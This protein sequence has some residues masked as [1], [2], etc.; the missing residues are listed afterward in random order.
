M[1]PATQHQGRSLC[2]SE[3]EAGTRTTVQDCA[4][5]HCKMLGR[6]CPRGAVVMCLN[7]VQFR[8]SLLSH[9]GMSAGLDLTEILQDT[10][11][12][13]LS[14]TSGMLLALL[15]VSWIPDLLSP[16]LLNYDVPVCV[17]VSLSP[18]PD[19]SPPHLFLPPLSFSTAKSNSRPHS[20]DG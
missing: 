15:A 4:G 5:S 14:P 7:L 6:L 3:G 18:P 17:F 11:F 19:I 13:H 20:H 8:L 1:C 12:L 2:C 9:S 16:F 10:S